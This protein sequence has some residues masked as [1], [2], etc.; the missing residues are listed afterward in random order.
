MKSGDVMG[1][2]VLQAL[3]ESGIEE[4]RELIFVFNNDEEVGS[5]GSAPLLRE[6]ARQVDVGLV[7]E[8]S[9]S[10]EIVTSARKGAEKY[11]LEVVGVPAHSGAEPNRGRSAVIELAHKMIAIHHLNSVFPVSHS[12]SHASVVVSHSTSY[13]ILRVVIFQYGHL[14]N[15]DLT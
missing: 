9:R 6:I 7:L 2:Y 5:T 15:E 10:I 8:S 11:E 14:I 1:M 3:V 13:R 4:Y 12:M